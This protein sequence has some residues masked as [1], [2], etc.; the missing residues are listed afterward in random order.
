MDFDKKIK[1]KLDKK[2]KYPE[3]IR[4]L[5]EKKGYKLLGDG[6]YSEVWG[7]E[8]D[9]FVI[10]LSRNEDI[11]YLKFAKWAMKQKNNPYVPKIYFL[12]TYKGW[13]DY[14]EKKVELFVSAIEKLEDFTY[15]LTKV[16]W[17]KKHIPFLI[18]A[19]VKTNEMRSYKKELVKICSEYKIKLTKV[20]IKKC[21]DNFNRTKAGK[22]FNHIQSFVGKKCLLDLHSGNIMI[23]RDPIHIVFTDPLA[24]T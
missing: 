3:D 15:E 20:F 22:T 16:K 7:R 8:Q 2:W 10:K 21:Y 19:C 6:A 12:K 14:D 18:W 5:L 13:D 4:E 24:E 9:S 1:K 17:T 23:R 11:C